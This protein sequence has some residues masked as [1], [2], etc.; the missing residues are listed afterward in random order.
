L[1]LPWRC[2]KERTVDHLADGLGDLNSR[3]AR[4][5]IEQDDLL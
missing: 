4:P 2:R 3:V 1:P 5:L